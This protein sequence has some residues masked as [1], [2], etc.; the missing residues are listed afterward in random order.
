MMF[1][2]KKA[3]RRQCHIASNVSLVLA[4]IFAALIPFVEDIE[5]DATSKKEELRQQYQHV[6]LLKSLAMFQWEDSRSY[7]VLSD[8]LAV[9]NPG[10]L[11]NA[12]DHYRLNIGSAATMASSAGFSSNQ[13]G[14]QTNGNLTW[15][16]QKRSVEYNRELYHAGMIAAVERG[17]TLLN[18][19]ALLRAKEKRAETYKSI[20]RLMSFL[21]SLVALIYGLRA[22][23]H[24]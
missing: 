2:L 23:Q 20:L 15:F 3:S 21:S 14:L 18:E 8:I 5:R 1:N 13:L 10:A 17:Q 9:V 11:S 24:E 12:W 22:A 16:A 4:A 6:H 7:F 19:I